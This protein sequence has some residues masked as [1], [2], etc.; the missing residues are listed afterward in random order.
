MHQAFKELSL[1]SSLRYTWTRPNSA[2]PWGR[3][4]RTTRRDRIS[5]SSGR[6]A[7]TI[8]SSR[9]MTAVVS[10]GY[11]GSFS[12][13]AARIQSGVSARK[14]AGAAAN[15]ATAIAHARKTLVAGGGSSALQYDLLFIACLHGL[16]E[17]A[18]LGII[19]L[20]NQNA[21]YDRSPANVNCRSVLLTF[22]F[23]GQRIAGL[24]DNG[25]RKRFHL[26]SFRQMQGH[27]IHDLAGIGE[28]DRIRPLF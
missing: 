26:H 4:I 25:W 1:R 8:V 16:V 13:A 12:W 7:V 27:Q 18:H 19:F 5:I 3:R 10:I 23:V 2:F 22:Q 21:F 11:S 24:G 6:L 15:R 9:R 28:V 14:D 17:T 20:G